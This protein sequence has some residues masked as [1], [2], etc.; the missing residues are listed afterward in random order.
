MQ[1]ERI[2]FEFP[3]TNFFFNEDHFL[4]WCGYCSCLCACFSGLLLSPC[5]GSLR[6]ALVICRSISLTEFLDHHPTTAE[7]LGSIGQVSGGIMVSIASEWMVWAAHCGHPR[8]V[9]APT[10]VGDDTER[11]A[12]GVEGGPRQCHAD[13]RD[14]PRL[15]YGYPMQLPAIQPTWFWM[16]NRN[17]FE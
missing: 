13:Y 7:T 12:V 10:Q 14:D 4:S 1:N 16:G 2:C 8:R 9:W 6:S 3:C 15:W 5:P 11:T 17:R